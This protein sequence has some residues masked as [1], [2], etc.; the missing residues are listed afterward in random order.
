MEITRGLVVRA[1]AGRDMGGFFV[2]LSVD[3]GYA[4][5]AISSG[6]TSASHWT[7]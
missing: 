1:L 5:I 4:E 3:G 6:R 2:V 7:A